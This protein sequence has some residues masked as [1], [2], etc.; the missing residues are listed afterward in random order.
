MPADPDSPLLCPTTPL[1]TA[2]Q[3]INYACGYSG[4]SPALFYDA[5]QHRAAKGEKWP[6][7]LVKV[8]I[9]ARLLAYGTIPTYI[10]YPLDLKYSI[11]SKSFRFVPFILAMAIRSAGRCLGSRNSYIMELVS[12]ILTGTSSVSVVFYSHQS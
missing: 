8:V 1:G 9:A 2:V 6:G 3:G 10:T 7:L 5:D 12:H 4:R 11:R